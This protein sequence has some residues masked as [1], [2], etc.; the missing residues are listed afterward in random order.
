MTPAPPPQHSKNLLQSRTIWALIVAAVAFGLEQLVP[1]IPL[2]ER[3]GAIDAVQT[4][5]P[6]VVAFLSLVAAAIFRRKADGPL[7]IVPNTTV[8]MLLYGTLSLGLGGTAVGT[9]LSIPGCTS[10]QAGPEAAQRDIQENVIFAQRAL[11]AAYSAGWITRD[12]WKT[13]VNP[14]IQEAAAFVNDY[15]AA[16]LVGD[17]DEMALI[18]ASLERSLIKLRDLEQTHHPAPET[19]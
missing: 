9:A 14:V 15:D 8:R 16:R 2:E 1:N 6:T 3:Q 5:G 19:P 11:L 17:I 18:R 7:T 12:T 13:T 4:H 10:Q